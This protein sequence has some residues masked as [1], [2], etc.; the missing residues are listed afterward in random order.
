LSTR[1][2]K[3]V[4]DAPETPLDPVL[5]PRISDV[6]VS[7]SLGRDRFVRNNTHFLIRL[8]YLSFNSLLFL[9][10]R[11]RHCLIVDLAPAV[12]PCL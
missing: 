6:D 11:K 1:V 4:P 9:A 7:C 12:A 3:L 8:V 2:I 5:G 10:K